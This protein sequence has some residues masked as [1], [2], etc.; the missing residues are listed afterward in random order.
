MNLTELAIHVQAS[1]LL[2]D[3][4]KAYW[5]GNL[6]KMNEGQITKLAG[7]LAEAEGMSWNNEMQTYV[8][9]AAVAA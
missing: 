8:A 4:E 7:I 3:A 2:T 1:K 9:T 5:I 6:P